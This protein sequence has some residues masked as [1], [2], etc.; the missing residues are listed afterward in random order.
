[1]SEPL[2]KE[3][4]V[5]YMATRGAAWTQHRKRLV[6]QDDSRCPDPG[7]N[8]SQRYEATCV[9]LEASLADAETNLHGATYEAAVDKETIRELE[10]TVARYE[11]A[12]EHYADTNNWYG[13]D[14]ND[15]CVAGHLAV[16]GTVLNY[17]VP[18]TDGPDVARVALSPSKPQDD[19]SP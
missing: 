4:R 2:S 17:D 10:A 14:K 13:E 3:E 9:E 18:G 12:L 11:A 5:E 15:E 19:P 7:P 1:M 6:Q 16:V 8:I